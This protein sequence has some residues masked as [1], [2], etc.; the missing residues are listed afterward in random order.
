MSATSAHRAAVDD[1]ARGVAVAYAAER[2]ELVLDRAYP[3]GRP[4]NFT[5]TLP[6][7]ALALQAKAQG[8]K[9]REDGQFEVRVKLTSLRR[10]ARE[11]LTQA[12]AAAAAPDR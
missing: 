3:P 5:V 10:E 8:S 11:T 7:G 2:L 9:R 1:G 12:F 6:S 4:L